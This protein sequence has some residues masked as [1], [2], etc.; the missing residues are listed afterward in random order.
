A[1]S[2]RTVDGVAAKA[3]AKGSKWPVVFVGF[4][5]PKPSIDPHDP[6]L[7]VGACPV[8]EAI[9]AADFLVL[10]CRSKKPALVVEASPR[11]EDLAAAYA[12]NLGGGRTFVGVARVAAGAAVPTD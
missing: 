4:A 12:R 1:S 8:D 7:F 11:G 3:R 10:P 5:G 6:V 9:R 2:S